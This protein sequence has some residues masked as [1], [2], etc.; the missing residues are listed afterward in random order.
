MAAALIYQVAVGPTPPFYE[1]CIASV[2]RYCQRHNYAHIVER[3]PKLRIAPLKSARSVNALRLGYL[4]IYEKQNAFAYLHE[5]DHVAVIDADVYA[6]ATAPPLFAE[7]GDAAFGAV[8]ERDM[9]LTPA[10]R[11]KVRKHSEGQFRSLTD[12]DWRW[13]KDG[14]EYA[15]MGVMVLGKRL[16]DYLDGQT[17]TEFLRRSEFERFINGEGHWKWSTDQTLLNWWLKAAQVPVRWLDWRWN[18]LYGA[19]EGIGAAH[20]VHL[21]LSAKQPDLARVVAALR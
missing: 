1:T 7:L 20:F 21:F 14:A 19:C 11:E 3:E 9:P 15:N 6:R 8:L 4:P 17:P 18:G 12:V 13:T 5:Y 2:A 10:Y 16:L